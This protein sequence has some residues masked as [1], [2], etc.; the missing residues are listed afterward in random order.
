MT[1]EEFYKDE[2]K[3]EQV[4]WSKVGISVAKMMKGEKKMKIEDNRDNIVKFSDLIVGDWFEHER[5]ICIK[6]DEKLSDMK[7]N[8]VDVETGIMYRVTENLNVCLLDDVTLV[9]N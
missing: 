8:A 2:L 9:L 6:I 5:D 7:F 3:V 1:N 4:D